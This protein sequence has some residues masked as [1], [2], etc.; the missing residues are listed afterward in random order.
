MAK[1]TEKHHKL[2]Q[3]L[4]RKQHRKTA[5]KLSLKHEAPQE[6]EH[7]ENKVVQAF[8]NDIVEIGGFQKKCKNM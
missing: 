5:Q 8:V 2:T 1:S 7:Q 4:S 6:K 3:R